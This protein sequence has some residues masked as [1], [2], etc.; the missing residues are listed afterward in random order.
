MVKKENSLIEQDV[1]VE[2]EKQVGAFNASKLARKCTY[3][4]EYKA[5]Y[6]YLLR[7]D[8]SDSDFSPIC[9]LAYDGDLENMDFAIYK[10]SSNKYDANEM[11]FPG[12][13]CVDG[14]LH[15]AMKAGMKAY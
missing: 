7:S 14:T 2:V 13:E 1:R 10:Y 9:R 15:G 8:S 12:S 3:K 5:K 6:I 4:A 11:F